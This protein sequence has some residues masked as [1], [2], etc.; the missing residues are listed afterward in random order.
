MAAVCVVQCNVLAMWLARCKLW[1][2]WQ[3]VVVP[4]AALAGQRAMR[5]R[6]G[7]GRW[8]MRVEAMVVQHVVGKCG[9]RP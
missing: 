7:H 2:G 4:C 1:L 5:G 3:Y 8:C 9:G 6:E